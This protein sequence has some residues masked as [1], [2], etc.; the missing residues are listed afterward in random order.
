MT[1]RLKAA[2]L[3]VQPRPRLSLPRRR[4]GVHRRFLGFEEAREYARSLK[5][6]TWLDWVK[7]TTSGARPS[8]IPSSP[9]LTYREHWRGVKDWLESTR[10][11]GW[12]KSYPRDFD[13]LPRQRCNAWSV[14][15][16]GIAILL[17]KIEKLHPD[18]EVIRA[19][20]NLQATLYF[21]VRDRSEAERLPRPEYP[22][23]SNLQ[24]AKSETKRWLPLR[25]S[26]ATAP[27]Y[28]QRRNAAF[29]FHRVIMSESVRDRVP[30][31]SLYL[32][33]QCELMGVESNTA[34]TSHI[35]IKT[36]SQCPSGSVYIRKLDLHPAA[37]IIKTLPDMWRDHS[38]KA[39][40]FAELTATLGALSIKARVAYL[41]LRQ[42]DAFL[43][44]K[45]DWDLQG[46]S[47]SKFGCGL[48]INGRTV[49][50]RVL[51]NKWVGEK[52][53]VPAYR[54]AVTKNVSCPT[55]TGRTRAVPLCVDEAPDFLVI[56]HHS[57]NEQD[58]KDKTTGQSG[59]EHADASAAAAV[60]NIELRGA[61]LLPRCELKS[62]LARR[63]DLSSG[64]MSL[65]L[66]P[67][68]VSPRRE[69]T[70]KLQERQ[71][72]FYLD[73]ST[74]ESNVAAVLRAKEIF[75]QY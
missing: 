40:D 3:A 15:E 21:R 18:V 68:T 29:I 5:L 74:S 75:S 60:C 70:R 39:C 12:R 31:L 7:W 9:Q 37:D 44:R 2:T 27:T 26:V 51:Q 24:G 64:L 63:G 16:E 50:H 66:Y 62:C 57:H 61:W 56:F 6:N 22:L 25:L 23:S 38:S 4:R 19:P 49:I 45:C 14:R 35:D 55:I 58:D 28:R 10:I 34:T 71:L 43:Y 13:S 53:D 1:T 47:F 67:P 41:L 17:D 20:F 59:G 36:Q 30:V 54:V 11:A 33:L 32:A 8:S 42:L 65:C 73:F 69:S 48:E 72:E 52:R 46:S